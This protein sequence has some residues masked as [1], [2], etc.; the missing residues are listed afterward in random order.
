MP[1]RP[2]T[3][4]MRRNISHHFVLAHKIN[5]RNLVQLSL[6]TISTDDVKIRENEI[7]EHNSN[8]FGREVF[9]FSSTKFSHGGHCRPDCTTLKSSKVKIKKTT[10]KNKIKYSSD[11]SSTPYK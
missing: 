7:V 8:T 5:N 2:H 1:P 3:V 9:A 11:I 6:L 10:L 4:N